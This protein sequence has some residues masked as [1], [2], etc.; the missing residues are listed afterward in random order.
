MTSTERDTRAIGTIKRA[1]NVLREAAAARDKAQTRGV[2]LALWDLRP[3]VADEWLIS[4]WEA[5]GSD[6]D[7]GRSQGLHAA[8][9][10]IVRQVGTKGGLAASTEGDIA[11]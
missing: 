9:N 11:R 10:G 3:W 4:F 6:H 2:A 1:L 7:I 5:A 8:Y